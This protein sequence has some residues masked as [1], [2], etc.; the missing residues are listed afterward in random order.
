MPPLQACSLD[1]VSV[2]F[3]VSIFSVI[4]LHLAMQVAADNLVAA[5]RA[6][7]THLLLGLPL[8]HSRQMLPPPPVLPG[9]GVGKVPKQLATPPIK[10][11]EAVGRLHIKYYIY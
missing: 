9:Q 2:V 10:H 6:S 7:T 11:L 3:R 8:L 4:F 1:V 5:P